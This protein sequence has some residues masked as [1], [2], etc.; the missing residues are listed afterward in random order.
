MTL[1]RIPNLKILDGGGASQG[2]TSGRRRGYRH[3]YDEREEN[4]GQ[5]GK[6]CG[7][8]PAFALQFWLR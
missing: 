6:E 3:K 2:R 7:P 8:Y 1:A 5:R 4:K